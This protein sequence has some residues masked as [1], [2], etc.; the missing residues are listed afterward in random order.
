[1]SFL[2]LDKDEG[3]SFD[4]GSMEDDIFIDKSSI[5]ENEDQCLKWNVLAAGRKNKTIKKLLINLA[6]TGYFL[7][8]HDVNTGISHYHK[9]VNYSEYL[10]YFDKTRNVKCYNGVF[11]SLDM[12][13][14][15]SSQKF[16]N[17]LF[18]L[19]SSI[20][21]FPLNANISRRTFFLNWSKIQN[22]LPTNTYI[23]RIADLGGIIASFY[24][25]NNF[26][27]NFE[28]RIQNLLKYI[29][30]AYCI[31]RENIVLYG[32][33]KGG[34]GALLHGI[35]GEYSTVAVD[36]IVSD[37]FYLQRNDMHYIEGCFPEYK[38]EK[39]RKILSMRKNIP[40]INIVT[41][42]ISEQYQYISSIFKGRNDVSV[43]IINHPEIKH[44]PDVGRM[45]LC[46]TTTLINSIFYRIKEQKVI[47]TLY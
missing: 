27:K 10:T 12:P 7:V 25:N 33:S 21:D 13:L 3:R 20:A 19:F 29:S 24:S 14:F 1:M 38:E 30:D 15:Q 43:H 17:R 36:P 8:G 32:G 11:Y 34:T 41:S 45:S 44:H 47:H 23:L 42:E 35:L 16:E 5:G 9:L 26:D 39:F 46:L 6:N 2:K 18:V 40:Y 22:Y 31:S 4:L 28:T 37:E